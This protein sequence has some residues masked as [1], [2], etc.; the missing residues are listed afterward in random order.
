MSYEALLEK[1]RRD[2]VFVRLPSGQRGVPVS[3]Q[4]RGPVPPLGR[5][6]RRLWLANYF[7][8]WLTQSGLHSGTSI[9][10]E[11]VSPSAQTVEVIWPAEE[12]K[13]LVDSTHNSAEVRVD[14]VRKMQA[15]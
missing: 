14:I 1:L 3:L 9:S 10:P 4:F 13:S 8:Q 2:D 6:E 11:A 15:V 5:S 12:I 7:S